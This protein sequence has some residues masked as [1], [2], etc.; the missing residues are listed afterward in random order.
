MK[1]QQKFYND[2]Y[3]LRLK[4]SIEDCI[5][6]VDCESKVIYCDSTNV[7][8]P[9]SRLLHRIKSLLSRYGVSEVIS[10]YCDPLPLL[11]ISFDQPED[12][13]RFL[14]HIKELSQHIWLLI[15]D[16]LTT[17]AK[18][19]GSQLLK[20]EKDD[21]NDVDELRL[22]HMFQ[23]DSNSQLQLL[24]FSP[25]YTYKE[26][27]IVHVTLANYET[28][29][30]MASTS[31]VFDVQSAIDSFTNDKSSQTVKG[32]YNIVTMSLLF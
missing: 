2:F 23:S 28:V 27:K 1:I 20:S 9:F 6:K 21:P 15:W 14:L 30:Q 5:V 32:T 31:V 7:Q 25:D 24:H 18:N 13:K 11:Q 19:V 22:Q 26:V 16:T 17:E 12:I 3:A 29:I 4:V 10:C 8:V